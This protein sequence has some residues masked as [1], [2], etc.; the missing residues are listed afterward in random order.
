MARPVQNLVHVARSTPTQSTMRSDGGPD[1]K[2]QQ[3]LHRFN[4]FAQSGVPDQ[5]GAFPSSNP[6]EIFWHR[7]DC[8]WL[9]PCKIWCMWL[10]R[11]RHSQLCVE[12]AVLTANYSKSF[13][14]SIALH[15]AASL[16]RSSAFPSSDPHEIFW[17]RADCRWLV[18]CQICCMWLDRRRH[19]QLCVE[20]RASHQIITSL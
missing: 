8:R 6:H 15:R 5:L 20:W 14:V 2:L 16:I 1:C 7:A 4:G 13:T 11:R 10:D 19:S 18:P 9:I 3:V 17:H 12:T